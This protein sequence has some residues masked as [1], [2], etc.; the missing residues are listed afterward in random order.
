MDRNSTRQW[1]GILGVLFA[2]IFAGH[3]AD[4]SLQLNANLF[5][6]PQT[7]HDEIAWGVSSDLRAESWPVGLAFGLSQTRH[8]P[9]YSPNLLSLKV[10]NAAEYDLGL[11]K[12]WTPALEYGYSL[13][14]GCYIDGGPAIVFLKQKYGD[15]TNHDTTIG[16][17]VGSGFFLVFFDQINA[18]LEVRYSR[19]DKYETV[20]AGLILGFS[21]MF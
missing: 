19:T 20:R 5:L 3:T 10:Q 11:R 8:D 9:P 21:L 1:L 13:E 16:Y 12:T 6:G 18:G 17:W 4:A 15:H 14:Y 7:M 2:L